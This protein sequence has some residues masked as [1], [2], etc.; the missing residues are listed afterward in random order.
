MGAWG[1][2]S[3]GASEGR[4]EDFRAYEALGFRV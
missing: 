1:W 3:I 2:G 4:V